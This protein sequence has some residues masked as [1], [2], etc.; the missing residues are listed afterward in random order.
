MPTDFCACAIYQIVIYL[1]KS[2]K[3]LHIYSGFKKSPLVCFFFFKNKLFMQKKIKRACLSGIYKYNATL[4]YTFSGI[5]D[6]SAYL[7]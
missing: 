1:M 3:L 4:I 7:R 6:K 2:Y 5:S